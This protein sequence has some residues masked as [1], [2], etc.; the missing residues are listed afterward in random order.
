MEN[1][2]QLPEDLI[3][4]VAEI[5]RASGK[6]AEEIVAEA[7]RQYVGRQR[8]QRFAAKN[9]QRARELGITESDIPR[10]VTDVRERSSDRS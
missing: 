8:L 5:A 6:T 9:E 2:I 3:T 10:L 7:T 4:A 1:S